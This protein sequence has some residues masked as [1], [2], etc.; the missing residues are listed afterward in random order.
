MS[1]RRRLPNKRASESF[2]FEVGGLRYSATFSR[3]GDGDAAEIFL[4]NTN[5]R[6]SRM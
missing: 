4:T 1:E 5:R 3:F 2:S 6:P